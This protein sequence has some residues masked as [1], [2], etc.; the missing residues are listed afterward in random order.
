MVAMRLQA[1]SLLFHAYVG[2][3]LV[4]ALDSAAGAVA[5]AL[6]LLV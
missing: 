3:R 2:W 6:L 1:I 5:V 4:P